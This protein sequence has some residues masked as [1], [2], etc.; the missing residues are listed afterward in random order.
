MKLT[1]S[2]RELPRLVREHL[3]ERLRDRSI[4]EDDLY[5]LK[6]WI[7]SVPDVPDSDWYRDFGT[8]KI[9]GRGSLILT[10]LTP[11]QAGY[12]ARIESD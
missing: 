7:E 1:T 9:A 11:T 8:F 2:W 10:F 4:G 6:L 5:K 3:L 12:G